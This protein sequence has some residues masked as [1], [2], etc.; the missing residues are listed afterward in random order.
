MDGNVSLLLF[1][2]YHRHPSPAQPSPAQPSSGRWPTQA[3]G[4]IILRTP[5]MSTF[6]CAHLSTS[7]FSYYFFFPSQ[8]AKICLAP[9]RCKSMSCPMFGICWRPMTDETV[10]LSDSE[11]LLI[12]SA[13]V[14]CLMQLSTNTVAAAFNLFIVYHQLTSGCLY[15]CNQHIQCRRDWTKRWREDNEN[16]MFCKVFPLCDSRCCWKMS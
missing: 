9:P 11:T 16:I 3:C 12:I 14:Q 8:N 7:Y 1:P 2:T 13:S 5:S 10:W 6:F 15:S 4:W